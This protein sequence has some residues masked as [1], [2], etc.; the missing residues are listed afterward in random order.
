MRF[1]AVVTSATLRRTFWR[2][3]SCFWYERSSDSRGSSALSSSLLVLAWTIPDRRFITLMLVDPSS[4]SWTWSL[5]L[6]CPVA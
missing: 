2:L 4:F 1:L 6:P 3:S 5:G